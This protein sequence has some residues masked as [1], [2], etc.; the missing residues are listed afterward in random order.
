M[1]NINYVIGYEPFETFITGIHP[2]DSH[3]GTGWGLEWTIPDAGT[4][5]EQT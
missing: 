4:P 2:H 5:S 3:F 1:Q